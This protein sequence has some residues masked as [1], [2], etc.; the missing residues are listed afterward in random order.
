MC[1]INVNSIIHKES[2][3]V[4]NILD[5]KLI[6]FICTE[7]EMRGLPRELGKFIFDGI[8]QDCREDWSETR[9]FQWCNEMETKFPQFTTRQLINCHSLVNELT[10]AFTK[11]LRAF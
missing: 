6:E 2:K 1:L 10:I 11:A 3:I 9:Y 8:G 5:E 4:Y 7:F